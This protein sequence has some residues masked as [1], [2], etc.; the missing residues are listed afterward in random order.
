MRNPNLIL[1]QKLVS[2]EEAD[3]LYETFP[4]FDEFLEAYFYRRFA[5]S[6][7][8]KEICALLPQF[9]PKEEKFLDSLIRPLDNPIADWY[10]N[11]GVA[12]KGVSN[13]V[14]SCE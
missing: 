8:Q 5:Y 13:S 1:Y 7:C 11:K 6:K 9:T 12:G 3:Y 2:K 10:L 14:Q 4:Y